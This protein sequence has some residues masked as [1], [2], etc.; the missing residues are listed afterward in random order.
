MAL[1]RQNAQEVG[2]LLVLSRTPRHEAACLLSAEI[3]AAVAARVLDA[4]L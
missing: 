3:N 1:L 2:S 4:I